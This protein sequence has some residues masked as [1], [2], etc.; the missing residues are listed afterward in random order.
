MERFYIVS[1]E[2]FHR[3]YYMSFLPRRPNGSRNMY[4]SVI[5]CLVRTNARTNH[6]SLPGDVMALLCAITIAQSVAS[7]LRETAKTK[8]ELHDIADAVEVM[9]EIL[10]Q[11]SVNPIYQ[12]HSDAVSFCHCCLYTL[13]A[14][15]FDWTYLKP[16]MQTLPLAK[17]PKV[18]G[19]S[20]WNVKHPNRM[21]FLEEIQSS[22][23]FLALHAKAFDG[24][25]WNWLQD[26][27]ETLE[28]HLAV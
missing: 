7:A 4:I 23:R 5:E 9:K 20:V 27:L 2:S 24:E 17:M 18:G 10:G 16:A 6:R 14:V 12:D 25:P 3:K 21:M 15:L 8:A 1:V 13:R 22:L 28:Y 26:F 19:N 11:I